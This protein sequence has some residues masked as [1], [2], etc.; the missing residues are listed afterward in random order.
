VR[1]FVI[2]A[3]RNRCLSLSIKLSIL[4][5]QTKVKSLIQLYHEQ[6]SRMKEFAAISL[7]LSLSLFLS[8]YQY[9]QATAEW[10]SKDCKTIFD[11]IAART[12]P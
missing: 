5:A 12:C 7:S 8:L 9:R 6:Q 10:H 4:F 11:P 1:I 2:E 3:E